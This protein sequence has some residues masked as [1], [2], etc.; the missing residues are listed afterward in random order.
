MRPRNPMATD[1][2]DLIVDINGYFA[3]PS[4]GGLN[5]YPAMPCRLL[6]TRRPE[7]TFGGPAMSAQSTRSF[8]VAGGA[9]GSPG[10]AQAYSLNMTVV[11]Q[12]AILG[13]LSTWPAGGTQ[14]VVSSLNA[15]KGQAVAN[16]AIVP[17]G[18]GSAIDLFV[19]DTTHV[20]IDANGYFAQ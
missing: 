12:S 10:T 13:Y 11:P 16:A 20:I 6:D 8:P 17:A 9:C 4:T 18:A 15:L 1:T 5:F 3:P 2:T 19:T 14:P 7:G